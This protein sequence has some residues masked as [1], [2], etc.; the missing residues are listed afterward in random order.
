MSDI[1]EGSVVYTPP[2]DPRYTSDTDW[3]AALETIYLKRE[4]F[5]KRIY[6][7]P[8]F[9]AGCQEAVLK[10]EFDKI[11]KMFYFE[12]QSELKVFPGK[13]FTRGVYVDV[14]KTWWQHF[15][16]QYFPEF[17]LKRFPVKMTPKFK[18]FTMTVEE[19]FTGAGIPEYLDY[20][21]PYLIKERR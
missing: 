19:I 1:F 21:K 6:F 12:L 10:G 4:R 7:N 13:T 16:M 9:F 5:T 3:V 18:K 8:G 17:L 15:K 14:P 2:D 11:T 20:G